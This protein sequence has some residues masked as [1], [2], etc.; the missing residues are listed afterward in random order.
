MPIYEYECNTCTTITEEW[1]SISDA[2]LTACPH[3]DGSLKKIIS[4]SSFRLKGG[5]WY[6]D[7]YGNT[8][9]TEC[10][11]S[12]SPSTPAVAD[13]SKSTPAPAATS[14]SEGCKKSSAQ[15]CPCAS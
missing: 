11:S 5:G 3:C 2:P 6:A 10:K 7:G 9:P 15:A 1:Q 13:S 8:K 14:S 4:S 12:G